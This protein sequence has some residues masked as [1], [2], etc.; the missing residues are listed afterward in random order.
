MPL[1]ERFGIRST[2]R[3]GGHPIHPMLVP[4]PIAFLIGALL[5]DLAYAGTRDAFWAT[6]SAWLV[7]AGVVGGVL[8]ALAGVTDFLGNERIRALSD[9]W[10]HFLGNGLAMVL[11]LV[12][13]FLRVS[14]GPAEALLP[15]GLV[16]SLATVGILAYTGWLGGELVYHHRVGLADAEDEAGSGRLR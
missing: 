2:A 7:G 4:F 16:L 15:W 8:A 14:R 12:S 10:H 11:S 6:A 13:L 1:P 5:S 9:A 3:I